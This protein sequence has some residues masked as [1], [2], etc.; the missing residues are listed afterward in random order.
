MARARSQQHTEKTDKKKLFMLRVRESERELYFVQM[1]VERRN[2][3]AAAQA[4]HAAT[5][6][7]NCSPNEQ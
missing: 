3:A 1:S 2:T 4:A 5:T 7:A 6:A